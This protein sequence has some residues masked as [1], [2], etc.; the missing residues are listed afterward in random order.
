MR[1]A[2]GVQ[3]WNG[4]LHRHLHEGLSIREESAGSV[5]QRLAI[6]PATRCHGCKGMVNGARPWSYQ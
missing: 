5:C 2:F 3:I 1:E 4:Q 6:A